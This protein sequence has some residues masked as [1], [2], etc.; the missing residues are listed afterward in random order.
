[1]SDASHRDSQ[2]PK[3]TDSRLLGFSVL[4]A[5]VVF[6]ALWMNYLSSTAEFSNSNQAMIEIEQLS[7]FSDQAW[8]LPDDELWGFKKIPE[9]PFVMGSNP[10]IDRMAFENERWSNTRRQGSVELPLYFIGRFEV[11]IAQYKAFVNATGYQVDA[12]T[13][14]GQDNHPVTLVTWPDALAYSRWLDQQLRSADNT[15]EELK[16]F[17]AQGARVNLP[18]EA[19]W[20]KAARGN[21]GRIYPW[22]SRPR[23]DH[24]NYAANATQA[25]GSMPCEECANG[26]SDMSGNVWEL[27]RSPLQDYPYD[28]TDDR[29]NLTDDALWVMRG[30]SYSDNESLIRTAVRGGFDPG[31]RNPTIGFRVVISSL[32]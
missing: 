26:L 12:N 25:V 2:L 7:G 18:N 32:D 5:I 30:G 27:T 29:E 28:A 21:E 3:T 31:V 22:G 10:A 4:L 23:A 1:M 16:Q 24:A 15:P 11:T 6:V 9:G 19:E 8:Y 20:E 14:L 17:L 13:L